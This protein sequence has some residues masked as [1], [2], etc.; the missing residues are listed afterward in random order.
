MT[1][2]LFLSQNI[3]KK[4]LD[5]YLTPNKLGWKDP[6]THFIRSIEIKN[7]DSNIEWFT[8]LKQLP[9]QTLDYII[10]FLS[11]SYFRKLAFNFFVFDKKKFNNK[12]IKE[13][14]LNTFKEDKNKWDLS[15]NQCKIISI[16]EFEK[17]VLI[18][19]SFSDWEKTYLDIDQDYKIVNKLMINW[20]YISS[21]WFMSFI[22]IKKSFINKQI[23]EII[24]SKI[25]NTKFSSIKFHEL[26]FEKFYNNLDQITKSGQF[27]VINWEKVKNSIT[28]AESKTNLKNFIKVWDFADLRWY[29]LEKRFKD[30]NILMSKSKTFP[31]YSFSILKDISDEKLVELM[32]FINIFLFND[33]EIN[34]LANLW[35]SFFKLLEKKLRGD[36][37]LFLAIW[38]WVVPIDLL[39]QIREDAWIKF[40]Y[41]YWENTTDWKSDDLFEQSN[42][43][44]Y[45]EQKELYLCNNNIKI[46]DESVEYWLTLDEN[47][48]LLNKLTFDDDFWYYSLLEHSN[49]ENKN[50]LFVISCKKYED[51]IHTIKV[52]NKNLIDN[53]ILVLISFNKEDIK[54]IKNGYKIKSKTKYSTQDNIIFEPSLELLNI[55]NWDLKDYFIDWIY[56][57]LMND[58]ETDFFKIFYSNENLKLID[59]QNIFY[60]NKD[61]LEISIELIQKFKK[62]IEGKSSFLI[63]EYIEAKWTDGKKVEKYIQELFDITILWSYSHILPEVNT[64][65]WPMDF[66]SISKNSYTIIEFKLAS[67]SNIKNNLKFQTETYKK[68][69]EDSSKELNEIKVIFYDN[70]SDLDKVQKII[71]KEKLGKDKFYFINYEK[72]IPW[73]KGKD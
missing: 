71:N 56:W 7:N 18:S 8:S 44:L 53:K 12:K 43:F 30:I 38:N 13:N 32:E 9:L 52:K 41:H 36:W 55:I 70:K 14:L 62:H 63:R 28:R 54:W 4:E 66:I 31:N 67:N 26:H 72:N 24:S 23:L 10:N 15:K 46:I 21:N 40:S 47:Y 69:L 2:K 60:S 42:I 25:L 17:G 68:T 19:F 1:K 6:K 65:R 64:H 48:I 27:D 34:L 50:I 20:V 5:K 22:W 73:S 51:I 59:I 49:D 33:S 35:D 58:K 16:S 61:S 11:Y 37:E 3:D 57:K 45:D 39:K 29:L